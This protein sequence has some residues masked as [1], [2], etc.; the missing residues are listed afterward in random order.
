VGRRGDFVG[1]RTVVS[2]ISTTETRT[3]DFEDNIIYIIIPIW[4]LPCSFDRPDCRIDSCAGR[5][6]PRGLRVP[7]F[8]GRVVLGAGRARDKELIVR[9]IE[10]WA[11]N[12]NLISSKIAKHVNVLKLFTNI[13]LRTVGLQQ[14][15]HCDADLTNHF[16]AK[17]YL[18]LLPCGWQ[19]VGSTQN[20][21]GEG[22]RGD[23]SP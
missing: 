14:L 13:A 2:C 10:F 16:F 6:N 4:F 15:L 7:A 5:V 9:V 3:Y 21:R 1:S 12:M 17:R 8:A 18:K 23:A 22:Q 19:A 11:K 20:F